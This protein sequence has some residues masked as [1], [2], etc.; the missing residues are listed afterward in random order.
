MRLSNIAV[1]LCALLTKSALGDNALE[2]NDRPSLDDGNVE[3]AFRSKGLRD[4]R[5]MQLDKTCREPFYQ[6][7][8][9]NLPSDAKRSAAQELGYTSS[10]W[11]ND[12][13]PDYMDTTSWKQFSE[14]NQTNWRSLDVNPGIYENGFEDFFFSELPTRVQNAAKTIGY[15]DP[16]SWDADQFSP[17]MAKIWSQLSDAEKDAAIVVGF[18]CFQWTLMNTEMPTASIGARADDAIDELAVMEARPICPPDIFG[19]SFDHTPC[20]QLSLS[21]CHLACHCKVRM[22]M[23]SH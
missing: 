14:A 21:Q 20:D 4:R 11:D 23:H 18:D 17:L 19:R 9:A 7:L 16:S 3:D 12:E 1:V 5:R 6:L 8:W 10:T 22:F 15:D 13:D 2:F